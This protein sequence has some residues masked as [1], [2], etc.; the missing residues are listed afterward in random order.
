MIFQ[1]ETCPKC[2]GTLIPLCYTTKPPIHAVRCLNCGWEYEEKRNE[3]VFSQFNL[4]DISKG[5]SKSS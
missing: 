3:V 2:G 5:E 4:N 1:I